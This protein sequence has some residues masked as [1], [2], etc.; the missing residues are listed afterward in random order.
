MR[1]FLTGATGYIGSAVARALRTKHEVAA[2]VRPDADTKPL[3]DLGV[4][5]VS[6]DLHSLPS[7]REQ[8]ADF[9]AFVHTAFSPSDD[10][11]AVDLFT[12]LPGHFVY[13]SG[14]WMLGNTESAHEGSPVN[15][16]AISAWRAP[17]E[18]RVLGSG[19]AV[20]RPG[21]VYGGKQ[22]LAAEWFVAAEQD[23]PLRIIGDGR[24]RWAWVDLEE[25]GD[26]YL[27]AVER[28]ATGVLHAIDDSHETVEESARAVGRSS[29]VEHVPLEL[30]RTALGDFADAL[31]VDQVI[32]SN[33][34]REK[35]GWSPRKTFVSSV[36]E[37]WREWRST[38]E[39]ID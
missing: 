6:G 19:G 23:R 16:L 14:C 37:Q 21:C 17:H 38:R 8:V 10:H 13:T 34:S 1:I 22:S 29:D 24:N 15:P 4:V 9:D 25:L 33:E 20:V 26:F 12:A 36:D 3:R 5:L 39:A 27:R 7:L 31:A 2:L 35:L 32:A 28:R 18:E 11:F 30:A